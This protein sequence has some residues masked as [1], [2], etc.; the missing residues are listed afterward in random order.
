MTDKPLRDSEN[1]LPHNPLKSRDLFAEVK[2]KIK[3]DMSWLE[4]DLRCLNAYLVATKTTNKLIEDALEQLEAAKAATPAPAPAATAQAKKVTKATK[5]TKE[6]TKAAP[7]PKPVKPAKRKTLA[8]VKAANEKAAEAAA[9]LA[10]NTPPT[11]EEVKELAEI[12]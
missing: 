4:F 6:P 11:T 10:E 2:D 5:A 7:V 8:E 12:K 3:G 9:T 1:I